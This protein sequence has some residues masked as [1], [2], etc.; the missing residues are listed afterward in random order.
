M[1]QDNFLQRKNDLLNKKDKSS[2][3]KW[4]EKI[5]TLCEVI[6]KKDNYY[7]TSSCSGRIVVMVDQEKKGS[8]LFEF[9]SHDIVDG[10]N[11]IRLFAPARPP[12][13]A[14][15]VGKFIKK[16]IGVDRGQ[17]LKFKSEPMILHVA[18]RELKDAREFLKIAQKVGLK[19][20][21][22]IS[23]SNR[24]VVEVSGSEK[25]EFPLM[26]D[27][28]LLV[29]EEFLKIVLEKANKHLEKNWKI[30]RELA[31]VV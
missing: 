23:I 21:G 24:I 28:N 20:C 1:Q 10:G 5:A 15:G 9:V 30:I 7:T 11:F 4:D 27:G 13:S 8:G 16:K 14:E 29:D 3:G 6:N 22:I 2:I 17:N 31:R 19:K 18:C 12:I 25:I 26:K